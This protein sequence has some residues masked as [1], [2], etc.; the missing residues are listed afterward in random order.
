LSNFQGKKKRGSI[1][2]L[3]SVNTLF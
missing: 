1:S 2:I 3:M